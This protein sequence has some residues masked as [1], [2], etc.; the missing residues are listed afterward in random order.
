MTKRD[1][2][3]ILAVVLACFFLYLIFYTNVLRENGEQ[4]RTAVVRVSGEEM[5]TIDLT[6]EESEGEYEVE[7]II[8]ISTFEVKDDGVRMISSPCPK[9]VCIHRGWINS[10]SQT[11]VCAPNK[12]T[13]E[14]KGGSSELDSITR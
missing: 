13:I 8:G 3:L 10:S 12:V 4:E 14:I 6:E 11:I 1:K 9:K 2:L 7:G 5:M